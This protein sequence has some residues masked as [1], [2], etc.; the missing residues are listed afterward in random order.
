M[1]LQGRGVRLGNFVAGVIVQVMLAAGAAGAGEPAAAGVPDPVKAVE[2]AR[3]RTIQQVYGSVVAVYGMQPQGGGSGV[4]YDPAGY[5]LTNYHVVRAAGTQGRAGLADG[6][7]YPWKLIGLDPGGDVAIIRLEGKDRF[8][9]SRLGDSDAVRVGDFVMA[10]GNPFALAEDHSPTV[11]LGVVS[12]IKRYQPGTGPGGTMLVYGN[13]IQIDS[14]INPGN[15]GGPLFNLRGEVIGING[16]GAFEERG[17]VNVGVGFAISINQIKTFLPELLATKVAQHGTLDAT[18]GERGDRVVCISVN[19]DSQAARHGLELGDR[20][21][22]FEGTAIHTAN[23]FTNLISTLPAGWPVE[24]VF[25][26]GGQQRRFWQRLDALPYPKPPPAK[27]QARPPAAKDAKPDHQAAKKPE[28]TPPPTKPAD[29]DVGRPAEEPAPGRVQPIKIHIGPD[30]KPVIPRDVKGKPIPIPIPGPGGS[31]IAAPI[32]EPGKI[33]DDKLNRAEAERVIAAWNQFKGDPGSMQ[34]IK[35]QERVTGGPRAD[36]TRAAIWEV[37]GRLR[38]ARQPPWDDLAG[39]A[40]PLRPTKPADFKSLVLQGGDKAQGQPCYRLLA[41][42]PD[43]RRLLLWLS[44]LAEDRTGFQVRLLKSTPCAQDGKQPLT[45][46]LYSDYRRV[47][48]VMVP[49]RRRVVEGLEETAVAEVT[50]TD[51]EPLTEL[52]RE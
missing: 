1:S 42:H 13:C 33:R 50:A 39:P 24:V 12:G 6:Q 35:M 28:T 52:P 16:R 38:A 40:S 7:T 48:G 51:C 3:I 23:Q 32:G 17:R 37:N 26:H 11:T 44:V 25:E 49:L 43:G 8:P 2:E 46:V 31:P 9:Y 29:K 27:P 14:S 4:L 36:A 34:G 18:F 41:E 10:M 47:G 5:A 15:S 30:G 20:L 22:A 45:A 19:L 21:V